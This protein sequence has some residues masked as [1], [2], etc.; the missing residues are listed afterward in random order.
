[1][2]VS[3]LTLH[4]D[5]LTDVVVA[6]PNYDDYDGCCGGSLCSIMMFVAVYHENVENVL[7]QNR[8]AAAPPAL[9]LAP[10]RGM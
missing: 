8:N 7:G 10:R 6:D 1:M 2:C 9:S 5:A 3:A 4:L